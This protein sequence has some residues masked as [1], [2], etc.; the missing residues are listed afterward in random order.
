MKGVKDK[1]KTQNEDTASPDLQYRKSEK[2]PSRTVFKKI[3]YHRF[4]QTSS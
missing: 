1:K 3:T 4:T 2:N